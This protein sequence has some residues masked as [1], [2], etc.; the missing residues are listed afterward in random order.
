MFGIVS[1]GGD[2]VKL[3][4]PKAYWFDTYVSGRFYT[5]YFGQHDGYGENGWG[6]QGWNFGKFWKNDLGRGE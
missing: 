2:Y 5:E 1:M 3:Y 4:V 6:K